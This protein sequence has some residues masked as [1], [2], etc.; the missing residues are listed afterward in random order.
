MRE[1]EKQGKLN[2]AVTQLTPFD[3]SLSLKLLSFNFRKFHISVML[4][5]KFEL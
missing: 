5:Y 3:I 1:Q 2:S 4:Y